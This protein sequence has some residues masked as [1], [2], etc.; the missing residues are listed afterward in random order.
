MR[1]KSY[2]LI[3]L[4]CAFSVCIPTLGHAAGKNKE[5][6]V[7]IDPGHGGKDIGA[8][9][10]KVQEKDI[11]LKVANQLAQ[12]LKKKMKDV[13]VVMTRDDDTFISLQERANIANRNRGDLFISIHTNSVDK[14]NPNRKTVSGTSVYALGLHKDANNLQ[15]AQRENSVIEL[16]SNYHQK[17]S[18]FDPSKDESYIIFEMAQKKNL[19]KSLKFANLAQRELVKTAGRAD[20]GVKQAGFWVLWATSMPSVLVE[21]DFICNPTTAAFISSDNGSKKLAESLFNAIES[22]RKNSNTAAVEV[23]PEPAPEENLAPLKKTEESENG[24]SLAGNIQKV[25]KGAAPS[26]TSSNRGSARKRRSAAAKA[27]SGKRNVETDDIPVHPDNE[28]IAEIVEENDA[29]P[30]EEV[31]Q[32]NSDVKNSKNAKKSKTKEKKNKAKKETSKKNPY[33]NTK[34]IVGKNGQVTQESLTNTTPATHKS[35][36]GH[37]SKVSKIKTVYKIQ[38]L[39]SPDKLKEKN[40][41]FCGLKPIKSFKEGNLYKYTY[42]ETESQEEIEETLKKVKKLIPD[43]FIIKSKK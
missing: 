26:Q 28:Y 33:G 18:G 3:T 38:I 39:A 5:F 20:R 29:V 41:R 7:V 2:I 13:K 37:R 11:N 4:I 30:A 35:T 19:G 34:I 16:E 1:L 8:A 15:V 27:A 9:D 24:V 43:A 36:S 42:G 21:L 40:P 14:S 32:T 25:K 10:N 22:Y 23:E 6:V 17:Y 31:A 12:M